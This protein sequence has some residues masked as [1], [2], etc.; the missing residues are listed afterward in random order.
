M[1][2]FL[3]FP[4]LGGAIGWGTNYLA[5]KFLFWPRRPLKVGPLVFQGVIPRRRRALAR[6]IGDVVATELLSR[7]QIAAALSA[8]EIRAKAAELAGQAV[9]R[10]VLMLPVLSP[11]SRSMR[12]K[13]GEMVAGAVGREVAKILADGGQD[14]TGRVLAAVDLAALVT[15]RLEA[16]EWDALEAMVYSVAGRELKVIEW[17]GGVLGALVGLGQALVVL[18]LG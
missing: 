7:E 4:L 12:E 14:W 16:M 8:P 17:M 13:V 6:A 1:L 15:E 10:R 9:A 2:Y 3:M 5:I 11:F 18:L